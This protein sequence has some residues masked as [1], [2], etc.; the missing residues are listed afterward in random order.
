MP[1]PTGKLTE[2]QREFCGY[3]GFFGVLV[4]LVSLIQHFSMTIPHWITGI[5]AL[6]Y[7]MAIV[8]FV[9]LAVAKPVAPVVL[10]ISSVLS[11]LAEMLLLL[12]LVYSLIVLLL[13]LYSAVI[14]ICLF[15]EGYPA[16]LRGNQQA[17]KAEE[18]EWAGKL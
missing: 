7:A 3:T 2:G 16:R 17:R 11:L 8:A 18:A 6:V 15:I 12:S 5:M 14:A 4:A 13:C 9:L 10:V 1:E